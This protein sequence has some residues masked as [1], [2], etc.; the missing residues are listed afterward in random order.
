MVRTKEA[1]EG[2]LQRNNPLWWDALPVGRVNIYACRECSHYIVTQDIDKGVTPAFMSCTFCTTG[3]MQSSW[4]R[5]SQSLDPQYV[6]YRPDGKELK[7]LLKNPAMHDHIEGGGLIM[8]EAV[9]EAS[10]DI[11]IFAKP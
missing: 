10:F 6:W 4:Y 5:V 1:L 8:K 3:T 11:G 2:F 7:K 9:H